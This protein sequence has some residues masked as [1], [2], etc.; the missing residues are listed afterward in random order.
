[1]TGVQLLPLRLGDPRR[2]AP[3]W[4]VVADGAVRAILAA[5]EDGE[6]LHG[7][8]CDRHVQPD[9]LL[10]FRNLLEARAWMAKRLGAARR[11]RARP[12]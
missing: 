5:G 10:V 8:T 6:I 7:F 12:R 1:M 11:T 2:T 9:G 4:L 3:G